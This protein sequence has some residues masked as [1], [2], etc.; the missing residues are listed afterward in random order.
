MNGEHLFEIWAPSESVWSRWAK[1]V[2]FAGT[3]P[4]EP[5]PSPEVAWLGLEIL[6]DPITAVIVDLPGPRSVDAGVALARNGFRPVP[7][8]NTSWHEKP[9]VDIGPIF[10]RMIPGAEELQ[11]LGPLSPD[12][13]PAFLLDADRLSPKR[14]PEPGHFDN[15][16][17]VFPQDFPSASFLLSR[18]LHRVL[19]LREADRPLPE[20]LAHVLLR[21]REAGLE[22]Y[23]QEPAALEAHPLELTRPSR[24]RHLWYRA[25]TVLGLKRNSAGGFG[26]VI[27]MPSQGGGSGFG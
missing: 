1:P 15:R 7:L 19:V 24:F 12:A 13:P 25:L 9:L 6:A 22:L 20:D 27:P 2:L 26:S 5:P 10:H 11:R 14:L 17:V 21:W 16:W 23:A 4:P 3:H 8:Y 18:G